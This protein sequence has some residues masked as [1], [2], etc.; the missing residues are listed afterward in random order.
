VDQTVR[1]PA[2]EVRAIVA[3]VLESHGADPDDARAQAGHLVEADLL[4]ALG[5]GRL[6]HAVLLEIFTTEGV[7][8]EV[9]RTA[10]RRTSRRSDPKRAAG[11]AS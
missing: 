10:P 11:A 5:D 6:R 1:V 8:T 3:E 2:D 7:G 9:V 4:A